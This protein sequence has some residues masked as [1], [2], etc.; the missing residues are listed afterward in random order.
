MI[1]KTLLFFNRICIFIFVILTSN[2]AYADDTSRKGEAYTLI[3]LSK[4]YDGEMKAQQTVIGKL[5]TLAV[6][7][8]G[9]LFY[10]AGFFIVMSLYALLFAFHESAIRTA[11]RIIG[12]MIIVGILSTIILNIN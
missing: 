8:K 11:I 9:M 3:D 7:N 5:S 1:K 12:G 6:E 4:V 10:S 2:L